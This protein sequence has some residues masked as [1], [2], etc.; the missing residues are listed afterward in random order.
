MREYYIPIIMAA[1][2]NYAIRDMIE[3]SRLEAQP[4]YE[5]AQQVAENE[6]RIR[7]R[8]YSFLRYGYRIE[9]VTVL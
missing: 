7:S 6:V 1:E 5:M 9:K 8:S 2:E 3:L 4:S